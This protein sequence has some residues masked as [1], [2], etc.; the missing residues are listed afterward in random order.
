MLIF[1]R[2]ELI[3]MYAAIENDPLETEKLVLQSIR[4]STEREIPCERNGILI[5]EDV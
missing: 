1:L 5:R 3:S 4:E 2:G